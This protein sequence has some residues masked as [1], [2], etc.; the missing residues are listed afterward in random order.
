ML[1]QKVRK[2]VSVYK[3]R[4]TILHRKVQHEIPSTLKLD[5]V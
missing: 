1:P 5:S 4:D 2:Y 3:W